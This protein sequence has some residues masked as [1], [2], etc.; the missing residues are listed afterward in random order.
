MKAKAPER[1]RHHPY[2]ARLLGLVG[3]RDHFVLLQATPARLSDIWAQIGDSGLPVTY[4]PGKWSARQIMAHLADV[5]LAIGFRI[6]Q[7]VAEDR[8]QIQAFD[9][10]HW[11]HG[12]GSADASLA[13]PAQ[14]ALR[15]WNLSFFRSLDGAQLVRSG[16]HPERGEETV[17]LMIRILAGHD[18]NHLAQLETIVAE[19][20]R[21]RSKT[22][23]EIA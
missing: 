15:R 4:G 5:E 18:L 2:V 3:S 22:R 13:V 14:A 12:Y 21:R 6:R 20:R 11:A 1:G 19:V 9:Q 10:D 17:D 7:T 23:P 8:H 16:S